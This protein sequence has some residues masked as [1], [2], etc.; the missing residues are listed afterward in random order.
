MTLPSTASTPRLDWHAPALEQTLQAQLPGLRVEVAREI[1]STNTAL[2][3]LRAKPGQPEMLA[4]IQADADKNIR[5]FKLLAD[6]VL[7]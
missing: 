3:E 4:R 6:E 1:G 2:L 5:R 7:E